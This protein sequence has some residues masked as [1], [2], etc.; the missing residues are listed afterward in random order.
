ML[1]VFMGVFVGLLYFQTDLGTR[2]G[3]TDITGALYFLVNEL[4]CKFS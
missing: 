1:K 2:N 3:I 4:T